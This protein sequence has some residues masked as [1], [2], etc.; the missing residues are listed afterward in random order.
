MRTDELMEARHLG[1]AHGIRTSN[2]PIISRFQGLNI[3]SLEQDKVHLLRDVALSMKEL[4]VPGEE[5]EA[6]VVG[7]DVPLFPRRKGHPEYLGEY[8]RR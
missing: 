8:L 2:Y 4:G 1:L 7:E 6:A 3:Q 5:L